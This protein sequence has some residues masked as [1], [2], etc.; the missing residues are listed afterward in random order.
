[1]YEKYKYLRDIYNQSYI[2]INQRDI[3]AQN[4]QFRSNSSKNKI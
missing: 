3:N 1:M 2:V 4:S